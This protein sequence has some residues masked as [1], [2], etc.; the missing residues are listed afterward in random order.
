MK[1]I[2]QFL[3]YLS[4]LYHS[5]DEHSIHSPFLYDL[6]TNI[7]K[8]IKPYY[9][10][11]NIESVRSRLLLRS[12]YIS[13]TDFGTGGFSKRKIS[14]IA[15]KSLKKP[16][17]AE[18]LFRLVNHFNPQ[19]ILEIGTSLGITTSY[20]ASVKSTNQIHTLEGCPETVKI[21]KRTFETL[22]LTNVKLHEGEFDQTLDDVLKSLSS[23][24]FVFIDGNH[25]RN[26]TLKYFDTCLTYANKSTVIV[27][28]DIHW[29]KEMN[30]AWSII[31]QHDKVAVSIDLY[32]VGI[33][34]LDTQYRREDYVLR[35]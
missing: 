26:P 34:I 20:L 5:K 11:S 21:A 10:F 9:I 32:E 6:Y 22:Q 8:D 28:D 29:S 19:N 31:K 3:Q 12:D 17:S 25:R 7:I 18:L 14:D 35:F 15:A 33:A 16:K 27:L 23:L 4:Y 24:D 2:T 1:R 13:V 30:E